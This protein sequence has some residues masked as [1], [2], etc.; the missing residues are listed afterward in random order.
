M[1]FVYALALAALP[2]V[3][4]QVSQADTKWRQ[5]TTCGSGT[6]VTKLNAEG[7]VSWCPGAA[8]TPSK[9][10][11]FNAPSVCQWADAAGGQN[12]TLKGAFNGVVRWVS[13]GGT[14]CDTASTPDG[15]CSFFT[16]EAGEIVTM[17]QSVATAN[18]QVVCSAGE[19]E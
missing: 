12:V 15:P 17:E 7:I 18:A 6:E 1:R 19:G 16:V 8:T 5:G 4:A 10:L 9:P 13:P 14:A 11:K 2:L 3:V